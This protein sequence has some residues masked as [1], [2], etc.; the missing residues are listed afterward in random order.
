M[1]DLQM[2]RNSFCEFG[3]VSTYQRFSYLSTKKCTFLKIV[4]LRFWPSCN[5]TFK[6]SFCMCVIRNYLYFVR[7]VEKHR[8]CREKHRSLEME[9]S[10]TAQE[11]KKQYNI[12]RN[13][14]NLT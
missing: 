3:L 14:I 1:T 9:H 4:Y 7:Y 5:A 13:Y 11:N 10:T 6:K 2:L 8:W 12:Q